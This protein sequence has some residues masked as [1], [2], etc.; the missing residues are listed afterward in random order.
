MEEMLQ[1]W[2]ACPRNRGKLRHN[3]VDYSGRSVFTGSWGAGE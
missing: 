3:V 2:E 1:E